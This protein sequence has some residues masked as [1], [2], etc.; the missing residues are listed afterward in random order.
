M[1]EIRPTGALRA[2][3]W[4]LLPVGVLLLVIVLPL[5]TF[6]GATDDSATGDLLTVIGALAPWLGLAAIGTSIVLLV[7]AA[8]RAAANREAAQRA[9]LARYPTTS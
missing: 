2:W 1:D 6:G 3:G 7:M 5:F 9:M 4:S 8:K